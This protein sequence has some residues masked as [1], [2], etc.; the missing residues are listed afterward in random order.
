MEII[1]NKLKPNFIKKKK[2]ERN[3]KRF[4]KYHSKNETDYKYHDHAK[5]KY[6]RTIFKS[7]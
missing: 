2:K 5:C 6:K 3:K 4:I 7:R 1:P